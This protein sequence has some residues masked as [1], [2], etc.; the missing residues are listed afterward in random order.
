MIAS[1]QVFPITT[2]TYSGTATAKKLFGER[3]VRVMAACTVTFHGAIN[4]EII[5]TEASDFVA[6]ADFA[7]VTAS[8]SVK[9]LMS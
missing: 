6:S 3:L 8:D 7:S 1:Y 5:I 9:V 4:K 2:E